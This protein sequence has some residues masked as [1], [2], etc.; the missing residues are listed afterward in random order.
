MGRYLSRTLALLLSAHL[1]LAA[2]FFE[3]NTSYDYFRGI[4]DGSWNGN[5]GALVSLNAADCYFDG[6]CFQLG[7]SFGIYNWDGRENLVFK[8]AKNPL[9]E[10]FLTAG[11]TWQSDDYTFG[12]VYD[13]IFTNHF[14]IYDTSPSFDQLRFHAGYQLCYETFGVFGTCHLSTSHKKALG[15]PVAFRA[16]DQMN[17]FWG[18]TFDN[19]AK[20]LLWLGAPYRKSLRFPNKTA[21]VLT[22]GVALR[23][24]LTDN[25]YF[26]GHGSYMRAR[27]AHG[28]E[29]S[30]NYA[31]SVCIGITYSLDPCEGENFFVMPVANNANFL[32]DSNHN[33]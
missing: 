7:G 3:A 23:A 26:D 31:A 27:N 10:G 25:L 19:S 14:G 22:A 1:S 8:N 5:S 20:T 28:S 24:P 4:P 30:R 11:G 13:R 2:Y 16:I 15:I 17:L 12:L 29:Q 18:H 9:Y 33:Q 6:I 21:G 32:V